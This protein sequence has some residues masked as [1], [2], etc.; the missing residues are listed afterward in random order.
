MPITSK[1]V[2]AGCVEIQGNTSRKEPSRK[3]NWNIPI[4]VIWSEYK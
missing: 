3:R 2:L 4:I 1:G